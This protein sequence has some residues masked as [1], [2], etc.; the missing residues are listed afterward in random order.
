MSPLRFRIKNM[1]ARRLFEIPCFVFAAL[2]FRIRDAL[3]FEF[4][5]LHAYMAYVVSIRFSSDGD[6]HCIGA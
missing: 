2:L 1:L 4:H 6:V 3:A 5:V